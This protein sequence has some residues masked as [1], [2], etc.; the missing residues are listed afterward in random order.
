MDDYSF[1]RGHPER[2]IDYYYRAI[3]ETAVTAKAVIRTFYGN[4]PRFSYFSGCSFGGLQALTEVQRYPDDYDGVIAG[5]PAVSRADFL[6]T[7]VWVAQALSAAP[8]SHIPANKLPAIEAA[9]VAACDTLDGVKDGLISDPMK[10]RFDPEALRCKGPESPR[11]LTQAQ[12]T[13]L[14]KFYTGPRNSKGEPIAPGFPPGAEGCVW[15]QSLCEGS[16]SR[17]ATIFFDG[18]LNSRFSVRTFNFDDDVQALN[19]DSEMK[20]MNVAEANLKPFKDRGGK[21]I[22]EHGWA[23]GTSNPLNTVNY[24]RRVVA[25]MGRDAADGFLRLYMIPGMSHCG[26]PGLA[27]QPTG[28]GLNRFREPMTRALVSW[29]ESGVE[30][31]PII[32]T[33]YKIEGNPASGVARTRPLCPYPQV[34]VYGGGGSI[35]DASNFSCRTP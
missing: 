24:Y 31:G 23:D 20:L 9:V 34:A 27:D 8:G 35:D 17:R 25:T 4:G 10:C 22:I 6:S 19:A 5:A 33:K 32:A 26:G 30:P 11:C 2:R 7:F 1:G 18:M 28:P 21:L 29:V 13:A 16:A 14:R 15:G 3:H 12:T